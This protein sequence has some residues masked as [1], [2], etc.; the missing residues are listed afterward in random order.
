MWLQRPGHEKHRHNDK[1]VKAG[2]N[3]PG[4]Q[5]TPLTAQWPL[6]ARHLPPQRLSFLTWKGE[7]APTITGV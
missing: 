3:L 7:A 4:R 5:A 6:S 2:G 1:V